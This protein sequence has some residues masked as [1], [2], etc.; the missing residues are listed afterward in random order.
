KNIQILYNQTIKNIDSKQAYLNTKQKRI[1]Y[2][3][4][5]NAAGAYV[6]RVAHWCGVGHEYVMLPFRG[7]YY[8]LSPSSNINVTGLIY[9]IPNPEMPFLGIHFTRSID[10]TIYI[11]PSAMPALG[12]EH[13]RIFHGIEYIESSRVLLDLARL[14]KENKQGFRLHVMQEVG[15]LLKKVFT[16]TAKQIIPKLRTKHLIASGKVGIRP[17]LYNKK[18]NRL[19]MDFKVLKGFKSIHILNSISPAFTSAFSFAE[20]TLQNYVQD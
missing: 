5:V 20:W 10:G 12:R 7:S 4:L 17:Q 9:T 1:E 19:E 14:Y 3:L 18:D 15:H 11:G 13:Y 6:D 8:K 2:G 16:N